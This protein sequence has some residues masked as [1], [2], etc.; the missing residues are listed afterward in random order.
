VVI[1]HGGRDENVP[2]AQSKNLHT[3][4]NRAN[5]A[6]WVPHLRRR[7]RLREPGGRDRLLAAS[8]SLSAHA[9]SCGVMSGSRLWAGARMRAPEPRARTVASC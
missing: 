9:P 8:G 2:P 5:K 1:A 6:S 3:A 7:P 4:L